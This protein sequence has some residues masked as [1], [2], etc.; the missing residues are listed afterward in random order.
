MDKISERVCKA[1][2]L[3]DVGKA[4][5]KSLDERQ[6]LRITLR[7]ATEQSAAPLA[8]LAAYPLVEVRKP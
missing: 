2:W 8:R 1:P 6:P 7:F 5:E 4:A 3:F